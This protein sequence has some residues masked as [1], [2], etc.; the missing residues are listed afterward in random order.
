MPKCRYRLRRLQEDASGKPDPRSRKTP[1]GASAARRKAR[2]GA[3]A[4][5]HAES[6][7]RGRRN[8]DPSARRGQ[9]YVIAVSISGKCSWGVQGGASS[10]LVE[11]PQAPD[12]EIL[13]KEECVNPAGAC[14]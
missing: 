14:V 9:T 4:A 6:V 12:R 11:A 7:A 10:T 5:R 13:R 3:G 1:R 8:H 2:R